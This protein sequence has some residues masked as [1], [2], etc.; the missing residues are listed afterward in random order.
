MR[1][2]LQPAYIL[3]TRPFQDSS[4]LVDLLTEDCG[5]ISLVAKGARRPKSR[6][7]N[8][9]QPFVPVIVSWQGKT[10]LK[11][12][13]AIEPH[14]TPPVLTGRYLY[15]GLYVNELLHYLLVAGLSM[16]GVYQLYQKLLAVLAD[17]CLQHHNPLE[18]KNAALE[19]CLRRF[20]F[21]LLIELGYGIDFF[22]EALSNQPLRADGCYRFDIGVGFIP[23]SD[24]ALPAA[25][26]YVGRCLLAIGRHDYGDTSVR[27]AAKSIA[28]SAFEPHLQGRPIKSRELF[29]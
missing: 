3:H 15:S 22:H 10:A 23:L 29:R 24:P 7:R 14:T 6:Q 17:L 11:T 25:G 13:V 27:H 26:V 8:L 16:P 28:R 4:L 20:E 12:L 18:N 2:E 19:A 9:L 21:S 1:V 5:R